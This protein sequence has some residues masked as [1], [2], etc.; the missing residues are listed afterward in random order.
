MADRGLSNNANRNART[1]HPGE[2]ALEV[3]PA[4]IQ[5]R[6]VDTA[7]SVQRRPCGSREARDSFEGKR[8]EKLMHGGISFIFVGEADEAMES[9][10]MANSALTK[11]EAVSLHRD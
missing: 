3:L 6:E 5:G 11:Y 2:T 8:K 10:A 9:S 7:I 4:V 1:I